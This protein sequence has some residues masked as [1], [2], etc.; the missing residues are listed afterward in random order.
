MKFTF[1]IALLVASASAN[2]QAPVWSLKSVKNQAVDAKI[3]AEY[4]GFSAAHSAVSA[5]EAPYQSGME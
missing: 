5:K 4:A 3:Q 1:A 2:T